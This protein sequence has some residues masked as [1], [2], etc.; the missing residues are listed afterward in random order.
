MNDDPYA[1]IASPDPYAGLGTHIDAATAVAHAPEP[2]TDWLRGAALTGRSI[3]E[4]VLGTFALP[5]T[6]RVAMGNLMRRGVNAIAGTHLP[7][8][9]SWSQG[10][11]DALTSAG[12]PVPQT[13]GEKTGTALVR[14]VSGGLTGGGLL[15][16]AV[17]ALNTTSN[18]V[19]TGISGGTSAGA[20]ETARRMGGGPLAQFL[21]SMAGGA[22]PFIGSTVPR[23]APAGPSAAANAS[24]S[25]G[26]ASAQST[27]SGSAQAQGSGGGSTFGIVGP[28]ES[29]GLTAAQQ[30]ALERGTA[31]GMRATPGQASGSRALQQFEAKL[32]SQPLTSGPFNALK[33]ANQRVLNGTAAR[34]IGETGTAVDSDTLA[35]AS[36]RLGNVFESVRTPNRIVVADPSAT[37]RALDVIDQSVEGLLPGDASI[38]SNKLVQNLETLTQQSHIHGEQ[39][40]S[41]SSKLGRAAYKQMTSPNGD[42]DWG[43]ALYAVKDHVDDLVQSTLSAEEA[44]TYA[45][46]RTQYRNLMLLTSRTGIVNP[47]T[48]N[49]SG[50]A[51]ANK[52][53]QADRNGFLFGQNQSDWYNAAR[54][55]QAFKPIVGD[56]GTATRSML[57]SPTDFVL[58][59]PFNVATRAYLRTP[60]AAASAVAGAPQA[61]ANSGAGTRGLLN[62]LVIPGEVGGLLAQK[63]P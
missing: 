6:A 60:A 10:L 62:P 48:G 8:E 36:E 30:Q 5:N 42:R 2:D 11:S 15:G 59:L 23:P 26:T 47:S 24:V 55:A 14:G 19:R 34:A 39:L 9:Q 37:S 56:S 54:F 57:H 20:G 38:R 52:L 41:L 7:M 43:Q 61:F 50:A 3:G 63:Q 51:L 53:Q 31:L 16:A 28:D 46:A 40:G 4:G 49:I 58:S 25:P 21:A 17:P 12:A 33:A 45:A 29:A 35:R 1:G 22:L 44:A 13:E 18:L 32:E 27:V